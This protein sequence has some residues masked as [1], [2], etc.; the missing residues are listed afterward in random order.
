LA[1]LSTMVISRIYGVLAGRRTGSSS[2]E[3]IAGS[4]DDCIS[5]WERPKVEETGGAINRLWDSVEKAIPK[6]CEGFDPKKKTLKVKVLPHKAENNG[7]KINGI[8]F[9]FPKGLE[10]G[11]ELYWDAKSSKKF[12]LRNVV[13]SFSEP[14][15]AYCN[16]KLNLSV[17]ETIGGALGLLSQETLSKIVENISIEPYDKSQAGTF[18]KS[19]V[20]AV[21]RLEIKN[22]AISLK[23]TSKNYLRKGWGIFTFGLSEKDCAGADKSAGLS[24]FMGDGFGGDESVGE[25]RSTLAGPRFG[26]P[27]VKWLLKVPEWK[28][29]YEKNL[30]AFEGSAIAALAGTL[31]FALASGIKSPSGNWDKIAGEE[32]ILG[33]GFNI[34]KKNTK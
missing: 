10:I 13:F 23:I 26:K 15:L 25:C 5:M 20:I 31:N 3:P 24:Y 11:A 8:E 34:W 7:F 17:G 12:Q 28:T 1:N 6:A 2:D 19:M 32:S 16:F 18:K 22:G 29:L 30:T 33:S 14:I 9:Y 21:D 27:M 4:G